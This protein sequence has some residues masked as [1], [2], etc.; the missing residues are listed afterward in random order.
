MTCFPDSKE[1]SFGGDVH[2]ASKLGR[3]MLTVGTFAEFQLRRTC[4]NWIV[5]DEVIIEGKHLIW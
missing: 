3:K 4:T 1:T 5:A 2:P